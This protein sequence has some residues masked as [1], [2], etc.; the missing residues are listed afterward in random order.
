MAIIRSFFKI[1]SKSEG[2]SERCGAS[3]QEAKIP[4]TGQE[5][6]LFLTLDFYYIDSNVQT[7]SAP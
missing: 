2:F 6:E 7:K 5:E 3:T 4:A 1:T